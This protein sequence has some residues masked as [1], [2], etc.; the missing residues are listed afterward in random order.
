MLPRSTAILAALAATLLPALPEATA[1]T[2][3]FPD[4]EWVADAISASVIKMRTASG[5]AK[6]EGTIE[7]VAYR[8]N[9]TGDGQLRGPPVAAVYTYVIEGDITGTSEVPVMNSTS[10]RMDA[11]MNIEGITVE[12]SNELGVGTPVPLELVSVTCKQVTGRWQ[13]G[14]M[15]MMSGKGWFIAAKV[16]EDRGP[17]F[18]QYGWELRSLLWSVAEFANATVKEKTVD[19][20]QLER[21]LEQAARLARDSRR[22]EGCGIEEEGDFEPAVAGVIADLIRLAYDNPELFDTGL[23][24]RLA[25]AGVELGALGPEAAKP[26]AAAET[27]EQLA[28]MYEKRLD[29]AEEAKD[30]RELAAVGAGARHIRDIEMAERAQ[31]LREGLGC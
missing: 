28:E 23:L 25:R 9:M 12:Q 29:D 21:L 6:F 22:N 16:N 1:Q 3:E 19:L 31:S 8:G 26:E 30:C 2:L 11:V 13:V 14:Y 5:G 18:T 4:G 24:N 7:F 10:G 17:D 15:N 27:A 20:P